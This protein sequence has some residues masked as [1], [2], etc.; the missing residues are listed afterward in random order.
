M[1]T[2]CLG[3]GLR[4]TVSGRRLLGRLYFKQSRALSGNMCLLLSASPSLSFLSQ[5]SLL[6]RASLSLFFSVLPFLS[7]P[8]SFSLS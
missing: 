5:I 4:P 3:P 8:L 1:G 7:L 6:G 2:L